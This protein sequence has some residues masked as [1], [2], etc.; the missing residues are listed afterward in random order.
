MSQQDAT[1]F[2]CFRSYFQFSLA[3]DGCFHLMFLKH[4]SFC[5]VSRILTFCIKQQIQVWSLKAAAMKH[6]PL[7]DQSFKNKYSDYVLVSGKVIQ[8]RH[9]KSNNNSKELNTR[10]L[11]FL[12]GFS[13]DGF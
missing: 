5:V 7:V 2:I 10:V 1:I 3:N 13:F 12:V 11:N 9:N 8:T 4:W 6:I